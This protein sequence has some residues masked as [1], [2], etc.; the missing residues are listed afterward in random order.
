[1]FLICIELHPSI[2]TG[3]KNHLVC[4]SVL[5]FPYIR[6][7]FY[8]NLSRTTE[9][10]YQPVSQIDTAYKHKRWF[11]T[12]NLVSYTRHRNILS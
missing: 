11:L 12:I 5:A 4:V 6:V 9:F 10:S 3:M 7:A 8:G 2:G 1:M